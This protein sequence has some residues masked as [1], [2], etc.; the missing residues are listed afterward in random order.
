MTENA[1]LHPRFVL[2]IELDGDDDAAIQ[3]ENA[4]D[5][6]TLALDGMQSDTLIRGYTLERQP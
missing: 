2:E 5:E 3:T 6:L 1:E 4:V